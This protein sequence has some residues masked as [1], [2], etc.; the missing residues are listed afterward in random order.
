MDR[1]S[2]ASNTSFPD[3][4]L[5]FARSFVSTLAE[6]PDLQAHAAALGTATNT[7]LEAQ[8]SEEYGGVDAL[9]NKLRAGCAEEVESKVKS[10][11]AT[12]LDGPHSVTKPATLLIP[13]IP[14]NLFPRAHTQKRFR[15][16]RGISSVASP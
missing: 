3:V 2:V 5:E 12:Q 6:W 9:V 7:K 14:L 8:R 15:G 1:E 10:Q 11:V 4:D 16:I 13:L